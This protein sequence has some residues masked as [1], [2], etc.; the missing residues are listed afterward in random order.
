MAIE[1]AFPVC[2]LRSRN[3]SSDFR[4]DW[5]AKGHVRDEMPVHDVDVEPTLS[6]KDQSM[7]FST[8][9]EGSSAALWSMNEE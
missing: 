1:R 5:C 9:L 4:N 8:K 7:Y 3:T 2:S 6:Q